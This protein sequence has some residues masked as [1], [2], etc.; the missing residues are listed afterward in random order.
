MT[1]IYL[2]MENVSKQVRGRQMIPTKFPN[3]KFDLWGNRKAPNYLPAMLSCIVRVSF[4]K[5]IGIACRK[6]AQWIGLSYPIVITGGSL[7][8]KI[9]RIRSAKEEWKRSWSLG[10]FQQ[11]KSPKL[12]L[13]FVPILYTQCH[14]IDIIACC[15]L[16]ALSFFSFS[17][18]H[19]G[20]QHLIL[21]H[22]FLVRTTFFIIKTVVIFE[23]T[24]VRLPYLP[25]TCHRKLSSSSEGDVDLYN[26]CVFTSICQK[27]HCFLLIWLK[28]SMHCTFLGFILHFYLT[29]QPMQLFHCL[30]SSAKFI[31]PY[32]Q[33]IWKKKGLSHEC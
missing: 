16:M 8:I 32:L 4:N 6:R 15:L 12:K 10:R 3:K 1:V 33:Q 29:F 28:L 22:L 27:P 17:F 19:Q 7:E 31:K 20:G 26:E 30:K 18:D 11:L 5:L 13:L 21:V 25:V 9:L 2:V 14:L 24:S 23:L